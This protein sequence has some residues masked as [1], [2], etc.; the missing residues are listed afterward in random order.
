MRVEVNGDARDL[1]EGTTVQALLVILGATG[2]P[3]AVE[4]NKQIIPRAAH[5]STELRPGDILEIVRFVGGG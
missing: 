5:G 4:C 1:P 3:V 2:G